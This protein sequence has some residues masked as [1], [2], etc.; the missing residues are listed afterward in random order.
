MQ[1]IEY[2]EFLER[3]RQRNIKKG[4]S[5]SISDQLIEEIITLNI[6]GLHSAFKSIPPKKLIKCDPESYSIF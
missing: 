2:L 5:T 1:S 4:E 3:N 6:G